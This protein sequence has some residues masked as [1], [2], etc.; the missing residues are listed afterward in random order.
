M[1]GY[2]GGTPSI[3]NNSE[4]EVYVAVNSFAGLVDAA[5][6]GGKYVVTSDITLDGEV[7]VTKG[8]TLNMNGHTITSAQNAAAFK[9]MGGELTLDGEGKVTGNNRV[10]KTI[11]FMGSTNQ[12]DENYSVL[13]VGSGVEVESTNGYA[14]MVSANGNKSYGVVANV[15]G[16]VKGYYGALYTN[17]SIAQYAGDVV[18]GEAIESIATFNVEGTAELIAEESEC[19]AVYAAGF[20]KWNVASGATITGASA[21][22]I[23]SGYLTVENG[24]NL[25]ATMA[26]YAEYVNNG[27]GANVTGDG[28]TIDNTYYPGGNPVVELGD[29]VEETISVAATG[30]KKVGIYWYV[31]TLEQLKEALVA[32]AEVIIIGSD[33]TVTGT[34]IEDRL[35]VKA[36][37][38]INLNGHT[39]K[40]EDGAGLDE[41]NN[42]STIWVN[43]GAVVTIMN[44]TI[45]SCYDTDGTT[46]SAYG[47]T[48]GVKNGTKG[49]VNLKDVTVNGG[50][51]AVY[52]INGEANIYSGEYV[53]SIYGS[54][55]RYLLN[56][57]DASYKAGDAQFNVY[58]GTFSNFN[59]ADNLAEG[60]DTNFVA[61]GYQAIQNGSVYTVS[62][63]A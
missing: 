62:A 58:G 52:I 48:V 37:A 8:L 53:A 49:T 18:E 27:N 14:I 17:G 36:D 6:R 20:A 15:A 34:T 40:S 12:A 24:A 26:S 55:Y 7:V 41:S 59:P 56:C 21:I 51:T 60:A 25:N 28:I 47:I 22:Y 35:T 3:V 57:Y 33:I 4:Y 19:A 63:Q 29:E 45:G 16:T 1:A 2:P 31:K 32:E 10:Y 46:D 54:D 61:D 50:T 9:I 43:N 30:A 44:G 23:K 5:N 42:W 39:I 38:T 13:N 11:Y